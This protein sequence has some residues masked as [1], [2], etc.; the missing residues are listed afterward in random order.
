MKD[1][2]AVTLLGAALAMLAPWSAGPAHAQSA[3][4]LVPAS[5]DITSFQSTGRVLMMMRIGDGEL[6]PMVF[7]TGSDG[8]S[9][10]RLIVLV[11]DPAQ[12]R[13][14]VLKSVTD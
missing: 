13:N 6:I 12:K 8:H 4:P 14:W 1:K 3:G 9:I 10:D 7:D 5:G 11:I 2:I